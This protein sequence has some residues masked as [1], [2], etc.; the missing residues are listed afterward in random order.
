VIGRGVRAA[1]VACAFLAPALAWAVPTLPEGPVPDWALSDADLFEMVK[2]ETSK[3]TVGH[4]RSVHAGPADHLAADDPGPEHLPG[5]VREA[6]VH[7]AVG[8]ARPGLRAPAVTAVSPRSAP[9][10]LRL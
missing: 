7:R 3:S 4:E 9:V 8:N 1:L 5:P 2:A 10:P 6:I